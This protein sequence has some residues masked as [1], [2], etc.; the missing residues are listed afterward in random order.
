MEIICPHCKHV[1]KTKSKLKFTTC[2]SCQ[3]KIPVVSNSN[4]ALNEIKKDND[5][6]L[7][8]NKKEEEEN[9][10]VKLD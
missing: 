9:R 7:N 5:V 8:E 3:K 1:Q 10:K 6:I 2:S 4:A